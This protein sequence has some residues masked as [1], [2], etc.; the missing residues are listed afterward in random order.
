[1][2][3]GYRF[4]KESV[5]IGTRTLFEV[6]IRNKP[7]GQP[8]LIGWAAYVCNGDDEMQEILNGNG[9][10]RDTG[11]AVSIRISERM[12][13]S[14]VQSL[15]D[16]VIIE[17]LVPPRP[18]TQQKFD[19]LKSID[20]TTVSRGGHLITVK[21]SDMIP[22]QRPLWDLVKASVYDAIQTFFQPVT[23]LVKRKDAI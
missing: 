10:I 2:R 16:K 6:P 11:K 12:P 5:R 23:W 4:C 14:V 19:E 3:P 17:Y 7:L 15:A 13:K 20:V 21:L 8:T 1:M 18:L 9:V 22:D